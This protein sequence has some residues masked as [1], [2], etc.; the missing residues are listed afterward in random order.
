MT[1]MLNSDFPFK[2][3][4]NSSSNEL[5]I[6]G[7]ASVTIKFA[8]EYDTGNDELDT[9][10]G[11]DSYKYYQDNAGKPAIQVKIKIKAEQKAT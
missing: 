5:D 7:E 3:S 1:R 10:Y 6:N 11:V 4:T 8:W 9:K 2:I